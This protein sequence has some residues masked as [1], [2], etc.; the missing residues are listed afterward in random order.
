MKYFKYDI[1][2]INDI[3]NFKEEENRVITT[4]ESGEIKLLYCDPKILREVLSHVDGVN[5]FDK[6]E[7]KLLKKYSINDIEKFL[8]II[9]KE[10]IIKKKLKSKT[11]EIP[12]ILVIGEGEISNKFARFEKSKKRNILD[13]LKEDI[14]NFDIAIFSPS[15]CTYEELIKVNEKLYKY[16]KP[17]ILINFNGKAINIGPFVLPNKTSCLECMLSSKLRNIN[18]ELDKEE[19]LE[20]DDIQTLQFSFDIEKKNTNNIDES[21]EYMVNKMYL[22]IVK[23]YNDKTSKYI[24]H[25]FTYDFNSLAEEYNVIL[26][27]TFCKSCKGMN[28]KYIKIRNQEEF[29]KL[30]ETNS[31]SLKY[32]PIKYSTGGIRSKDENETKEI[33]DK[34][35]LKLGAKLRIVYNEGNPFKDIAPSYS[36]YCEPVNNDWIYVPSFEM[37]AGKGMTKTQAY[38]SAGFEIIEHITR[39]YTGDIQ[40]IEAKYK[41]VKKFAIDLPNI[42]NTIMN[43]NTSYDKF[44]ENTEIDWVV[45]NSVL[46]DEKK[47]IPAFMTFMF[48]VELKGTLFGTSSTGV[49]SGSTLED[50]ILHGLF[51]VIEHDAWII[52]QSNP[53][54]LPKV[55]YD[56]SANPKIKEIVSKIRMMGYDIVTRDYT[57]DLEIPV[58]RTYITNRNNYSQYSYNGIGCHINP[59]IALERSITEAIQFCDESFGG[60]QSSL[61]TNKVLST[62]LVAIYNQHHVINKDVLGKG[63]KKTNL[64]KPKYQFE[65]SLELIQKIAKKIK[66][67]IDGNVY[68][69]ELT[70][71][72][73]DVK[74]VRVIVTGDIQRL[75][76]PIISASKRLFEFGIKC[77][78]SDKLTTYEELFMGNY[79]H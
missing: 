49:A 15:E 20:I 71:P 43:K 54:V 50:A 78:Y 23:Q 37:G 10:N 67:E 74:V 3:Y 41:D 56:S 1:P 30:V 31:T 62:S 33:L 55:N 12:E 60:A 40:I 35:L 11:K 22:E 59:E 45:G 27:T 2:V 64:E 24:N 66:K 63:S 8:S 61:V 29:F 76:H 4:F 72:G 44:D 32:H 18:L 38:F 69:V 70:K 9:L 6:I 25:V 75:N 58:Y 14:N 16:S 42:S 65:S 79:Q 19:K 26:P 28:K 77:G 13:F 68:Y 36:A 21:L 39:Q 51:E 5:T 52:G 7:R 48:D 53:Y 34:E 47:L 73:M 57:N 17:Y 46:S